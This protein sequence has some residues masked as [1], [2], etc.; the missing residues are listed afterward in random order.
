MLDTLITSKTRIKMLLKFFTNSTA[1]AYLRGLAEEFGESTNSIRHELNNLSKAG[2]LVSHED[3][4]TIQYR[5]NT[6]HPLFNEVRNLVHKYLGFDKIIDHVLSRLGDLQ[7]AFIVGDYAQGKDTGTIEL[8]LV[9]DINVT[10]LK[11]LEEKA[12]G[13]LHRTI[14]AQVISIEDFKAKEN[15]FEKALLIWGTLE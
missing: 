9:G 13:L 4:R 11:R 3:G 8:I 7:M 14:K 2:Y 5:A 12:K 6:K 15:D 10:Y 1:S